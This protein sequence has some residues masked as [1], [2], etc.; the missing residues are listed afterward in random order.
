MLLDARSCAL[1]VIDMQERL[2]PALAD[3]AGLVDRCRL[4]AKAARQLAVPIL[5]TEQYPKGL[6]RTV[7]GL[8]EF[9]ATD[10]I[11]A[12]TAFSAM[13]D[14]APAERIDAPT[15]TL[16]TTLVVIGAET[17]VCVLQTVVDLLERGRS[18]AVV[19]DAVGSRR[20]YD[21]EV[22]LAR[23]QRRGAEIVTAEMV[24]FEWLERAATPA[25]KALA[26]LLR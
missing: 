3:C 18:V 12:K 8:S 5:A 26:P 4:V 21:K 2:V 24:V 15:G 19:A 23:M 6:G 1:L 13:R 10:D 22:G 11:L 17:H 9:I 16:P 25:F 14:T 7:T 20:S